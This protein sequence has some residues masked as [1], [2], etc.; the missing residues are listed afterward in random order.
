VKVQW[1]SEVLKVMRKER[2]SV[3]DLNGNRKGRAIREAPLRVGKD[4]RV[5]R[6]GILSRPAD[7]GGRWRG[8]SDEVE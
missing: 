1:D 2:E 4:R 5:I 8:L 6:K 3:A 7:E